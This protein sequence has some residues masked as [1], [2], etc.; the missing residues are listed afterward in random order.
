ML[1]AHIGRAHDKRMQSQSAIEYLTTYGWA[2]LIIVVA[3]AVLYS[4]GIFNPS[5]YTPTTCIL[6][7]QFTCLKTIMAFNGNLLLNIGQETGQSIAITSIGCNTNGTTTSMLSFNTPVVVGY[8][9]NITTMIPCYSNGNVIAMAADRQF[10]GYI[11]INYTNTDSGI[12]HTVRGTLAIKPSTSNIVVSSNTVLPFILYA[13]SAA[14]G[15]GGTVSCT[16][17]CTGSYG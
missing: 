5:P 10:T 11:I 14:A 13:F 2:I 15:T 17:A 8:G 6:P 16:P 12:S 3:F 9:S 1:P 7:S 4:F